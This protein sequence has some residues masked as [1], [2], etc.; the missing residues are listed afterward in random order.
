MPRRAVL[1][2]DASR[3]VK[4]AVGKIRSLRNTALRGAQQ[5]GFPSEYRKDKSSKRGRICLVHPCSL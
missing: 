2:L 3:Y 1:L 4:V 5:A